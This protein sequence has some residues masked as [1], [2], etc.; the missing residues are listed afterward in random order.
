M[1][2]FVTT[3]TTTEWVQSYVDPACILADSFF[4]TVSTIL[5]NM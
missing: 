2:Y 3:T 4:V 5:F 1:Y